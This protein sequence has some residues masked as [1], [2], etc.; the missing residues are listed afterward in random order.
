LEGET[1]AP[2]PAAADATLPS[3]TVPT[4][5]PAPPPAADKYRRV[6]LVIEGI[7]AGKIADINRGVLLPLSSLV[8]DMKFT[9]EIDVTSDEGIPKATLE[10]KIKETIRQIG[11]YLRDERLE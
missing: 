8:K 11:A 7:P 9:L 1:G 6:R 4:T 5:T 2:A 3:F 10:N